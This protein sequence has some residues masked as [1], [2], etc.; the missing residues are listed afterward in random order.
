MRRLRVLWKRLCGLFGRRQT[1]EEFSA[2]LES[3]LQL[4]VDDNL[5]SGMS[6]EQARREALLYLGGVEQAKQAYRERSIL[7][8]V[9]NLAADVCLAIRQLRKNPGFAGTAI[10]VLALGIAASVAIFAFVDAALM[11]P[12]PYENPS[13][14]VGVFESSS[15]CPRCP[16]SY[17]DYLD[18]K[19][20]NKVFSTFE[21]WGFAHYL[22]KSTAGV[23][24][25]PGVRVSGGFF[26]TLGVTPLLGRSFT[27]ADDRPGSSRTLL[28]TYGAWQKRFGGRKDIIGQ[29]VILDDAPYNIIGVLPREF[30][31]APRGAAEFWTTLHDP[32]NCE[33]NRYCHNLFGLARL[34]DGVSVPAAFDNMKAIAAQLEREY[35]GSNKGQG[36]LVMLLRDAIIGNIRPILLALLGCAGL[37]LLIACVNV[38]SLLLVKTENRKRELAVRGALG[39]SRG[40]LIRQFVAEGIVLVA[41]SATVGIAAAYGAIHLLLKLIPEDMLLNM[42]YLQGIGLHPRVLAFAGAISALAVVVFSVTPTLRLSVSNL[43]G[44]LAEGGRG[45]VGTTWKRFGSNLAAV[46]LAIAVVL[47]VSA[48]L[49]GKS[50]YRLLHVDLSFNPENLATLGVYAPDAAYGKQEQLIALSQQII[51]RISAMPGVIS[52][53]HSGML[54]V[55]CNCDTTWFRVVG[56]PWN[57]EHNDA[58]ARSISTDYFKTLQAKLIRGRFFTEA[59][60]RSRPTVVIINQALAKQYFPGEDP[61]GKSIGDLSLS[62]KSLTPIIGVVDDVR[63]GALDQEIRPV[64][65][66]AFKQTPENEFSIIV[67]TEQD[68][69][70]MLPSLVSAIRQIDPNLGLKNEMTMMQHID[71]SQTTYLHRSS[72]WL[73][74]GFAGIALLLGVVGLYGVIAYSVSQR[75]REIGVRIALGAQRKTIYRMILKEAG[76]LAVIG[77]VGGLFCS[78]AGAALM[79]DLLF[80]VQAWDGQTLMAV[81]MVLGGCALLASYLPARRAASVNPVDALRAE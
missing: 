44:D 48:G 81:A 76:L 75:T 77:I 10:G 35:P 25:V 71:D 70:A 42:P 46:E 72:A 39:A 43:R 8:P 47:L 45:S 50:F 69:A 40:R 2:E 31:F 29:S 4:H 67:R 21:A 16:L 1:E 14:L 3:H 57:G 60:D 65:Y 55:S 9:E 34:K 19:K 38:A 7:P 28:L 68:P 73:V 54:P 23:Q 78:I 59:D 49:L 18:W 58:P 20:D 6:V 15:F 63:E 51:S 41:S 13:R 27:D 12:L 52:V 80:E 36:A 56:H 61:I 24:P 79:R 22:W 64:V 74:G 32:T 66:Y 62:P 5:R 53:G 26:H 11:K 30:H 37:L 33:K 17:P